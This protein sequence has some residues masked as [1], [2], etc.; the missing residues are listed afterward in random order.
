MPTQLAYGSYTQFSGGMN[1]AF[2]PAGIEA[3]QYSLGV[4]IV[5]RGGIV[6]SR[7]SFERI[8]QTFDSF[9]N[10]ELFRRGKYQ[11]GY[12]YTSGSRDYAVAVISGILFA[13][14]MG[15]GQTF[16]LSSRE[17]GVSLSTIAEQCWLVE[18]EQ[19]LIIQ[20]GLSNPIIMDGLNARHSDPEKNEV[21]PGTAMAYGQ[22][23]LFVATGPRAIL[24]GNVMEPNDTESVLQFTETDEIDLG[25]YLTPGSDTGDIT[26][27][28]FLSN[29]DTSTGSGPLIVSGKFGLISLRVDVPRKEWQNVVFRKFLVGETGMVGPWAMTDMNTDTLFWSL[30][31]L[32][33]LSV[34]LAEVTSARRFVNLFKEVAALYKDDDA[35]WWNRM[36]MTVDNGRLLFTL[37]PRQVPFVRPGRTEVE[38]D[39]AFWG[40]VSLD[41]D[42]L[43]GK[44]LQ[45]QYVSTVSYDGVWTGPL[46]LQLLGRHD[47]TCFFAK[48]AARDGNFNALYRITDNETGMDD[49]TPIRSRLVTRGFVTEIEPDYQ[50]APFVRKQFLDAAMWLREV[51]GSVPLR[52][53]ISVDDSPLFTKIADQTLEAPTTVWD[54]STT[55]IPRSGENHIYPGMKFVAP[56][57]ACDPVTGGSLL[58]GYTFQ[59]CVD[60]EGHAAFSRFLMSATR[61]PKTAAD[62]CDTRPRILVT[63]E[64]RNVLTF[65]PTDRLP[66]F[67]QG[68]RGWYERA[69]DEYVASESRDSADEVIPWYPVFAW[70]PVL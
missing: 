33:S 50:P 19:F 12:W 66:F 31:G 21:P 42:H 49:G 26:A 62:P 28:S 17:G 39:T 37:G 47:R 58:T 23:R 16:N 32:R 48:D 2:D 69:L 27:M 4:N 24:A 35:F 13:T 65:I 60:W 41:F 45:G 64:D 68:D 25:G 52:L 40:V 43:R 30:G 46:F 55:D 54:E 38:E 63:P 22:G 59:F 36:S 70:S 61:D 10:Q 3:D 67:Y 51:E 5:G 15:T 7:P 44:A 34:M 9:T 29:V 18:A 20:D 8:V 1:A 6:R 56:N 11:G 57:F 14:D 53:A